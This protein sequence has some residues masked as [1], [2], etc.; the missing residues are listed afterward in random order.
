MHCSLLLFFGW[1]RQYEFC[2]LESNLSWLNC[3]TV[4]MYSW[5]L[6]PFEKKNDKC[7]KGARIKDFH[8][9][10]CA[11][12]LFYTSNKCRC[13]LWWWCTFSKW[14]LIKTFLI[15]LMIWD[16]VIHTGWTIQLMKAQLK[17][18]RLFILK[19]Y[20][21]RYYQISVTLLFDMC[22]ALLCSSSCNKLKYIE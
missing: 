1:E 3:A 2:H 6:M 21:T 4:L 14:C 20:F 17:N 11:V 10:S 9:L 12:S 18:H 22:N 8:T 19:I 15:L 7:E 16:K 5:K 13:H